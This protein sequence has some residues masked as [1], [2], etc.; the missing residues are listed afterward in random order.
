[1]SYKSLVKILFLTIIDFIFI[2]FWISTM[3]LD[4]SSAIGIIVIIPIIIILNLIIS[5]ILYLLKKKELSFL[6]LM[7]I[8]FASIITYFIFSYEIRKS[9]EK[10]SEKYQTEQATQNS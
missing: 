1:M 8:I 4:G 9:I 2:W 5:G 6:F 10:D 7:N 3:K